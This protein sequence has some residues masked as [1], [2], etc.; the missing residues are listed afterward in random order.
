VGVILSFFFFFFFTAFEGARS[1][2]I[3]ML[4]A[5][6][7]FRVRVWDYVGAIGLNETE[8]VADNYQSAAARIPRERG[9][10]NRNKVKSD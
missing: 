9:K 10:K 1:D 5:A 8:I 7:R 2:L 4:R 6:A 3:W